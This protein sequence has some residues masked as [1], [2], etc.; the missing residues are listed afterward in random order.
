MAPPCNKRNDTISILDASNLLFSIIS[1][2]TR[3]SG[4]P[5]GG[6][7]DRLDVMYSQGLSIVESSIFLTFRY[8][9]QRKHF[10]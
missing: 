7:R 1:I 8:D 10:E 2:K 6:E 9:T 4:M 5:G 3:G